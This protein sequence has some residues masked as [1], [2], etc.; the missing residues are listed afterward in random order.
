LNTPRP[1]VETI[2]FSDL[3]LS[4]V[5]PGK[6][7]LFRR[8]L[9]GPARKA[10]SL[11]LLGDL[12][13]QFWVGND[14]RTPPNEEIL[15]A[16]R[17]CAAAGPKCRILRGNR[18]L[19]LDA[20]FTALTGWQLLPDRNVIQVFGENVL[21]MHGDLLC[22]R[23]SGY[24]AFRAFMENPRIRWLYLAFPY[25]LRILLAHGLRPFLRRTAAGKPPEIIDVEP[26]AVR[27]EMENAG[28][29]KLIHGHT[30]R[31]GTYPVALA[32]QT[33]SRVVLGDWYETGQILV[34]NHEQWRLINIEDFLREHEAT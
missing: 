15:A 28:V 21:I 17:D 26:G 10:E 5:R 12:F 9:Q 30:H 3:H 23:D 31:P 7:E 18:D 33:G 16:M 34:C 14:D 32:H 1:E 2:F 19:M 27:R 20:G 6:L 8:L 29:A 25:A 22:T 4:P 24:Q 11:Y 13:E